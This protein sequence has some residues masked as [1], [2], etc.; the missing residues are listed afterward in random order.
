[1]PTFTYINYYVCCYC[2]H[3]HNYDLGHSGMVSE[4]ALD[5]H[6][7][8]HEGCEKFVPSGVPAYPK[9]W[10]ELVKLNHVASR[11]PQNINAIATSYE[12]IDTIK[13]YLEKPNEVLG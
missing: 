7:I 11:I 8:R 5:K 1:M 4:C 10:A 3:I 2:K 9:V 13:K 12:L 6:L